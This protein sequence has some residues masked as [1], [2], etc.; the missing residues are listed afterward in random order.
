M[1]CI[2]LDIAHQFATYWFNVKKKDYSFYKDEIKIT[3][4]LIKSIKTPN[5]IGRLPRGITDRIDYKSKE[6]ENWLLFYGIPI[7]LKFPGKSKY[8][9][10]GTLC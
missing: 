6:W 5:Q 10:L 4:K 3:E 1:H 8:L 7:L 9:K 2:C